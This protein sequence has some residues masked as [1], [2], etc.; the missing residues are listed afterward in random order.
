[1]LTDAEAREQII[2]ITNELFS[3]GLLT[4]TGG[5][6]SALASDGETLWITPSQMY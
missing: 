3:R 5:N 4:P 1:M 6:V 2:Q